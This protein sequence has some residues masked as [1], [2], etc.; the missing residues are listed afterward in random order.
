MPV[1]TRS[2]PRD[3]DGTAIAKGADHRRHTGRPRPANMDAVV[4]WMTRVARGVRTT[5]PLDQ[6]QVLVRPLT[7]S[8]ATATSRK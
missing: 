5:N 2:V 1:R 4:A 3:E 8:F 6:V 7:V